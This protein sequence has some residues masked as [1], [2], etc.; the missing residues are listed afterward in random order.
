MIV[1]LLLLL[2]HRLLDTTDQ[3]L[4]ICVYVVPSLMWWPLPLLLT[5]RKF[6][7]IYFLLKG[8]QININ[9]FRISEVFL[10]FGEKNNYTPLSTWEGNLYALQWDILKGLV[11]KVLKNVDNYTFCLEGIPPHHNFNSIQNLLFLT[12]DLPS[13]ISYSLLCGSKMCGSCLYFSLYHT[14]LQWSV[15]VY[16]LLHSVCFIRA[17]RARTP[18]LHFATVTMPGIS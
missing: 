8:K 18:H 10:P 5:L 1:C 11:G 14:A 15:Y 7:E 13:L 12:S 2:E 3:I 4:L 17:E 6:I 9:S 16:L